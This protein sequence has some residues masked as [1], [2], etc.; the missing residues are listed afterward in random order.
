MYQRI[1]RLGR[2]G[3][4]LIYTNLIP[5]G[6]NTMFDYIRLFW[7][8]MLYH[9]VKYFTIGFLIGIVLRLTGIFALLGV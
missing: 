6:Y 3:P 1:P 4:I 9:V 5:G 8:D 2:Y 7:K